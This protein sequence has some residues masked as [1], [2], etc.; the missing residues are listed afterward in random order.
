M[1]VTHQNRFLYDTQQGWKQGTFD[2]E[3]SDR[4]GFGYEW[5]R[6]VPDQAVKIET[7]FD[8]T[9]NIEIEFPAPV[10]AYYPG[11]T[12]RYQ[13]KLHSGKFTESWETGTVDECRAWWTGEEWAVYYY[14]RHIG[15]AHTTDAAHMRLA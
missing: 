12:V 14:V 9:A 11:E 5:V 15:H 2:R 4:T 3:L 1:S 8:K 7:E 13:T 6:V 10:P